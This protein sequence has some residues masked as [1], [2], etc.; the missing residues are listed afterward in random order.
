MPPYT[1][2]HLENVWWVLA[3]GLLFAAAIVLARASTTFSFSL[4]RRRDEAIEEEVHEFPGGVKEQNRPVPML[5]WLMIIGY[6]VWA[7]LYVIFYGAR[8]L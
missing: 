4:K 2:I 8:G 7:V 3:G 6:P 5:I 1:W